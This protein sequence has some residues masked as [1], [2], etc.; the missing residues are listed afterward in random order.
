MPLLLLSKSPLGKMN[1]RLQHLAAHLGGKQ[2]C[3][4][5]DLNTEF[6]VLRHKSPA[7]KPPFA[8]L[9]PNR[10]FCGPWRSQVFPISHPLVG[11]GGPSHLV[12]PIPLD[13]PAAIQEV[14]LGV[15][16]SQSQEVLRFSHLLDLDL[17]CSSRDQA[18]IN[19]T[20]WDVECLS[21]AGNSAK[22]SFPASGKSP[23][24]LTATQRAS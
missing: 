15:F 16:T 18:N 13:G 22:S 24:F 20:C 2:P 23:L 21:P 12:V 14:F 11:E 6:A 5:S 3:P 19:I 10:F 9:N 17:T 7:A 8:Y 4:S 1:P